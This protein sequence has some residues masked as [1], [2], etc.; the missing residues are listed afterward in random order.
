MRSDQRSEVLGVDDHLGEFVDRFP[1]R[2]VGFAEF[3]FPALELVALVGPVLGEGHL[4]AKPDL[5]AVRPL[6]DE[7]VFERPQVFVLGYLDR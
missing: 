5:V 1:D 2:P 7:R 4:V 3:R 6:E